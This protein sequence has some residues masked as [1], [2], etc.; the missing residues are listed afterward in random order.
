MRTA[1]DDFAEKSD[2]N[3][4]I[5]KHWYTVPK[6]KLHEIKVRKISSLCSLSP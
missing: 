5:P 2:F 1:F 3:P 6:E 4:L